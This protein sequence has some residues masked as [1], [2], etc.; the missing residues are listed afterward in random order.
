VKRDRSA[1][2]D[3]IAAAIFGRLSPMSGIVTAPHRPRVA[4]FRRHLGVI[5][6]KPEGTELAS[7]HFHVGDERR[8]IRRRALQSGADGSAGRRHARLRRHLQTHVSSCCDSPR[9][10]HCRRGAARAEA[11]PARSRLRSSRDAFRDRARDDRSS[12]RCRPGGSVAAP[13]LDCRPTLASATSLKRPSATK[14]RDTPAQ[15]KITGCR[16]H[17]CPVA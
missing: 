10:T 2:I 6:S 3:Q 4:K 15:P 11:E 7:I 12:R 13:V 1:P 5:L 14:E 16:G 9:A 8:E 17:P